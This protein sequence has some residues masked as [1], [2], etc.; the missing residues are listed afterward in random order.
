MNV[1]VSLTGVQC[2]YVFSLIYASVRTYLPDWCTVSVH[3][4]R[5]DVHVRTYLRDRRTVSMGD[6]CT[7]YVRIFTSGIQ[8]SYVSP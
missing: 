8:Y 3:D 4:S 1:R 6:R 5:I 7:L 2:P